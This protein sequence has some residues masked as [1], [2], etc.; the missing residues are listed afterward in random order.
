MANWAA[1]HGIPSVDVELTTH[2][3]TDFAINKRVLEY[4]IKADLELGE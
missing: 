3:D 2:G 1:L 4:F